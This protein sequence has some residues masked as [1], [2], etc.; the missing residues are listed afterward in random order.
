MKSLVKGFVRWL[1]IVLATLTII[2]W[3]VAVLKCQTHPKHDNLADFED[4]VRFGT[5]T[6]L[7]VDKDKVYWKRDTKWELKLGS[8]D[9]DSTTKWDRS[10]PTG[11]CVV[12][13]YCITHKF[14]Y[15][16]YPCKGG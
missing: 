15:T 2:T 7:S 11:G 1:L 13:I 12:L 9:Y 8:F 14:L 6:F 4:D 5:F 3:S 10:K 16:L